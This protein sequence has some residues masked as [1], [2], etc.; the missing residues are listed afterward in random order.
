[1]GSTLTKVFLAAGFAAALALPARA[2][3]E[4]GPFVNAA[5]NAIVGAARTGSPGALAGVASRYADL[6]S[7]AL[8][9]LGPHR[10]SLKKSQEEEYVRLT[11]AF[12]G[13]FMAEHAE[14]IAASGLSV[15]GCSG[16]VVKART[17]DG[18]SLAFKVK[19][20]GGRYQVADLSV[21]SV[22]L[23]PQLRSKFV[24]VLR[25][26]NGDMGALIRFLKA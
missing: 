6:R 4:A 11:R 1:M 16:E 20:S 19:K 23:A 21:A 24:S 25:H 2:D 7:I 12:I 15:T 26:H 5:G 9:A 22:W 17:A 13:R 10:A 18:R 3:C 8:F 14:R